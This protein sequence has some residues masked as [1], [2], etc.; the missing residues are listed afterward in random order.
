MP[1]VRT[2]AFACGTIDAKWRSWPPPAQRNEERNDSVRSLRATTR[3][4]LVLLAA[5]L[6][7]AIATDSA[8]AAPKKTGTLSCSGADA[9]ANGAVFVKLV[10]R[11]DSCA[12]APPICTFGQAVGIGTTPTALCASLAAGLNAGCTPDVAAVAAGTTVTLTSGPSLPPPWFA[13]CATADGGAPFVRILDQFAA[14]VSTG[15]VAPIGATMTLAG[16]SK[17]KG[18]ALSAGG[19]VVMLVLMLTV[20]S[21]LGRR[22]LRQT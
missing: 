8:N 11:H 7:L 2:T 6:T 14:G 16:T 22:R 1:I 13:V 12:T 5:S 17:A 15:S 20:L 18:P 4:L 21:F 19:W 10:W 3:C 9:T